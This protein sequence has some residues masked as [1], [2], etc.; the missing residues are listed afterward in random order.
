MRP[1]IGYNYGA[2][3]KKRIHKLFA[4]TLYL[5]LGIMLF[6]TILCQ[7]CPDTLIAL[8]S[9]NPDTINT[10]ALAL[11]TISL[12]F[13]VSSVSITCCGAL[14]G[15]GKGTPSLVIS[16]CRYTLVIIPAAFMLSR[17]F[18]AVRG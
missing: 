10:G 14:E 6:G 11:R 16:L 8:F 17:I 9:S 13:L 12:G 2:G 18:G 7:I 15:L 1:L 4:Y 3:K 5:S